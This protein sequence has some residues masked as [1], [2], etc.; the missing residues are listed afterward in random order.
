MKIEARRLSGRCTSGAQRGAGTVFHAVPDGS[1]WG[2]A[3]C[4]ARP[5]RRS[6][7]GFV[8]PTT[9]GQPITCARCLRK[10]TIVVRTK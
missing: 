10:M 1:A 9:P 2:E 3:L 8:E 4:G 7:C 6:G 5:G